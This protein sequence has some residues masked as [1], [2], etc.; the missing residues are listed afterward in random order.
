MRAIFM[1]KHKRSAVGA[2]E[3]LVARGREVVA[4]VAPEPGGRERG[5]AAASTSPPRRHGLRLA[6]DDE[7]Y[8]EIEDG[9]LSRR[10]PGAVV[11]LLA[12]H[13]PAADRAGPR[14]AA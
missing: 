8:A 6:T 12:A 1:G 4:V 9:S 2:L 11:P 13:P 10:R 7:L 3:H 5:P 14:W